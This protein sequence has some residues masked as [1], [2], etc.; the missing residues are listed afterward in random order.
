MYH[1]RRFPATRNRACI[2]S[3]TMNYTNAHTSRHDRWDDQTP[4]GIRA[5]IARLEAISGALGVITLLR[6]GVLQGRCRLMLLFDR[7]LALPAKELADTSRP[8]ITL[9]CDDDDTPSGP[10]GWRCA[11]QAGRWAQHVLVQGAGAEAWHYR[12]AIEMA[13]VCRRV[14]IV[15]T[16]SAHA[17]GWGRFLQHPATL[18]IKP[19]G[20]LPH[21]RPFAKGELH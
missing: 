19:P 15:D 2:E 12:L 20:D 14:L 4:D 9:V 13:L 8:V 11:K 18:V 3:R 6:E 21:P 5:M 1:Q 16:S 17:L 7:E 10:L